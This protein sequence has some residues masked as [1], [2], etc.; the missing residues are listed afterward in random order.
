MFAVRSIY[1]NKAQIV[2]WNATDII[3]LLCEINGNLRPTR[4]SSAKC[5]AFLTNT[6]YSP[7]T[8]HHNDTVSIKG[9]RGKG[10]I[11]FQKG[12]PKIITC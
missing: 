6:C 5:E 8:Y 3:A 4:T 2:V 7:L 12:L 1:T 9:E 11:N 10:T